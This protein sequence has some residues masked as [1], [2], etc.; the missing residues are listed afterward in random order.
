MCSCVQCWEEFALNMEEIK[1]QFPESK[2]ND[3]FLYLLTS[4]NKYNLFFNIVSGSKSKIVYGYFLFLQKNVESCFFLITIRGY[5]L[6][7]KLCNRVDHY[8]QF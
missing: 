8:M 4:I 3:F 7:L 1:V 2:M 5:F 6:N